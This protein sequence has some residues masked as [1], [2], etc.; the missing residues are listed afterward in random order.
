MTDQAVLDILQG[1]GEEAYL[2]SF[3]PHDFCRTFAS[4]TI[5]A[6]VDIVTVQN[7]RSYASPVTIARYDRRG[8]AALAE[9]GE[10]VTYAKGAITL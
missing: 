8:E 4:N 6:G 5:D 10:S 1:W 7:L 3:S 9:G 2:V